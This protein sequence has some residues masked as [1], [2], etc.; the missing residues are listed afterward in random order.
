MQPPRQ[1]KFSRVGAWGRGPF[2]KGL[3]PH[4]LNLYA[5]RHRPGH[6]AAPLRKIQREAA[7]VL[8][9]RVAHESSKLLPCVGLPVRRPDKHVEIEQRR[10]LR[11]A[12][13]VVEDEFLNEQKA[14]RN[15]RLRGFPYNVGGLVKA[16]AVQDLGEPSY[17]EPAGKV[18]GGKVPARENDAIGQA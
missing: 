5:H 7:D 8:K 18:F 15:E 2:S 17:I 6:D 4:I 14:A 11:P 13:V 16:R 12:A 9:P 3:L 10:V 1:S